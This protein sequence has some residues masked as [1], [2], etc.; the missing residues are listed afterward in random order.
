MHVYLAHVA[1][2]RHD[3][4]PVRMG[5]MRDLDIFGDATEA[6][7]IG[8]DVMHRPAPMKSLNASAV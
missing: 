7:H 1:D 8:L 3:R 5:V 4:K 6:C 2:M